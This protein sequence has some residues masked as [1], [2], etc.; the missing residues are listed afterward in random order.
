MGHHNTTMRVLVTGGAGFV[1]SSVCLRLRRSHPSCQVIAF[2]N[3]RR[4]GSELHLAELVRHGVRFVHGDIRCREDLDAV[5]GFDVM[6]EASAE[7][8]VLAG[9]GTD[10]AHVIRNNLYGSI[11][12]LD[13][14]RAQ[15]ADLVFLSTSRVYPIARIEGAAIEEE[16]TRFRFSDVQSTR[17]IS[18]QGVSEAL[19][20]DGA[21]SF[22]GA[23]KLASELFIREYAAF[24][25]LRAAVTRFG[26]IAG[27]RQLGKADQGIATY[28]LAAHHWRRPLRYIGFGGSGKQV[29]DYL[30]IDDATALIERQ[31]LD[32]AAFDGRVFNAGGGIANSASLRELTDRCI[33]IT[34]QRTEVGPEPEP[35]PADLRIYVTD[36]ARITRE[37]G[38]RPEKGLDDILS[39]IHRWIR[40]D[41]PTLKPFL[42]G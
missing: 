9:I 5:G 25:G 13:L 10:P 38:W 15:G 42:H 20:T 31:V 11:H 7:P 4:R 2:D 41:E 27:P 40:S 8:S 39:D 32:I 26:V 28:W 21:R 3:L 35:R 34:G 18:A 36:N 14:C 33:R 17:G 29:R 1:G 12:C 16:E 6:V 30:H 19:D 23:T 37:T 24:Y 22:Y